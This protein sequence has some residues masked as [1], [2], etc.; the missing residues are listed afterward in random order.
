MAEF[1]L[2]IADPKAGK[3]SSKEV[4]ENEAKV[5]LGQ[6]IGNKIS[7]DSFDMAGYEFEI[8][9][10]SD[11]AGFPMRK[12]I[13]GT[14]RKK[15]LTVKGVGVKPLRRKTKKHIRRFKGAKLRKTVAGNTIHAKI[16][17]INL[18]VLKYGKAPIGGVEEKVEAPAEGETPKKGKE[19]APAEAP[20]KEAKADKKEEAKAEKP[21]KEKKETPKEKPAEEE[22]PKEKVKEEKPKEEK[23]EEKKK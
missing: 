14:G 20:K 10:G 11:H 2:V 12:D 1:K 19:A 21:A 16:A 13:V 9:G 4:K 3:C 6:K 23:P 5:F 15:I 8:T 22:V 18:K 17:Q 7:G